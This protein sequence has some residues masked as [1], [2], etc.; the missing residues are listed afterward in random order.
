MVDRKSKAL[1]IRVKLH[2][3]TQERRKSH[4]FVRSTL[5][6]GSQQRLAQ[7]TFAHRFDVFASFEEPQSS[8]HLSMWFT[9]FERQH[10]LRQWQLHSSTYPRSSSPELHP[11]FIS[12]GS[13][14]QQH[15]TLTSLALVIALKE[16]VSKGNRPRAK[17]M[18]L[19]DILPPNHGD[20]T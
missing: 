19:V 17:E 2:E 9:R 10:S 20:T 4:I 12:N 16:M 18:F 15:H 3:R 7:N 8:H 1:S 13:R 6:E 11:Q 5:A 14:V